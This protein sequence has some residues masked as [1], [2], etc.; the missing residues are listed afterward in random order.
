MMLHMGFE[1]QVT[2]IVEHLGEHQTLLFSATIPPAIEKM[3]AS[4]LHKP[5]FVAVGS[6]RIPQLLLPTLSSYF[7]LARLLLQ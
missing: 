1:M 5:A 6:V 3:G 7:S 4:I 2:Q